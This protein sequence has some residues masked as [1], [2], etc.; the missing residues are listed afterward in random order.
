MGEDVVN[1]I[2]GIVQLDTLLAEVLIRLGIGDEVS[3]G[4]LALSTPLA[5]VV[6]MSSM[7]IGP[8]HICG[9]FLRKCVCN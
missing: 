6:V 1:G 9:L 7:M 2:E 4:S 3:R 8:G 5:A